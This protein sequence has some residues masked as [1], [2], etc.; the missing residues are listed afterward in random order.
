MRQDWKVIRSTWPLLMLAF[1]RSPWIVIF[2]SV[3][4]KLQGEVLSVKTIA[5]LVVVG[6]ITNL[7]RPWIAR[8]NLKRLLTTIVGIEL[9]Y[10]GIGV[11]Y[12]FVPGTG[13]LVALVILD[14]TLGIVYTSLKH[15]VHEIFVERKIVDSLRLYSAYHGILST[16]GSIVGVGIFSILGDVRIEMLVMG[17]FLINLVVMLPMTIVVNRRYIK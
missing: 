11:T 9:V 15:G 5:M 10:V 16:L 4:C 1:M 2:G 3:L 12:G 17:L 8:I 13:L 6:N 14:G 7:G